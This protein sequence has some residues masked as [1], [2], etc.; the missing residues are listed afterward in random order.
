M[1]HASKQFQH[2]RSL[3]NPVMSITAANRL[4][5]MNTHIDEREGERERERE[6][7]RE[8]ER[9][10]E[11]GERGRERERQRETDRQTERQRETETETERQRQREILKS[12]WHSSHASLMSIFL[13]D[14]N[15]ISIRNHF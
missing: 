11:R 2:G 12:N 14:K 1:R 6:G 9:G 5:Q 10:R 8:G 15:T 3:S 7:E 4:A 13:S